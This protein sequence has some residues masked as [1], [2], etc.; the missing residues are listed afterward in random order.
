VKL[1]TK[2]ALPPWSLVA[3]SFAGVIFEKNSH[4]DYIQKK[5]KKFYSI[6]V[7]SY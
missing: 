1:R 2:D 5:L 7:Y 3:F 4:G 6:S